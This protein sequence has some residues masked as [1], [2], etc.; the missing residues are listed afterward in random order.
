[1]N[2]QYVG[3]KTLCLP[4]IKLFD[5][6]FEYI[7]YYFQ[8]QKNDIEQL[9]NTDLLKDTVFIVENKLPLRNS[10]AF[11]ATACFSSDKHIYLNEGYLQ[12][13]WE[14][15][16]GITITWHELIHIPTIEKIIP[17][18]KYFDNKPYSGYLLYIADIH[19]KRAL[20][21]LHNGNL[22]N[23]YLSPW[24]EY[25]GISKILKDNYSSPRYATHFCEKGYVEL[26]NKVFGFALCYTLFHEVAHCKLNHLS[27]H[28]QLYQ[29]LES[30][31]ITP[32]EYGDK[33]RILE[34]E[35]DEYARSAF[36][37][38][39]DD[40]SVIQVLGSIIGSSVAIFFE[41]ST[42]RFD[43]PNSAYRLKKTI[44]KYANKNSNSELYSI[45]TIVMG[46]WDD[47]Y[48]I[49]TFDLID[50]QKTHEETFNEYLKYAGCPTE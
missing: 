14:L 41:N 5:R 32:K 48:K 45:G 40:D 8:N 39:K 9:I 13:L 21:F 50:N 36:H 7:D 37:L 17:D 12:Y 26:A 42:F 15:S 27:I 30:K 11:T 31:Q 38:D 10:N 49:K 18:K 3:K 28:K 25:L 33:N 47:N 43:H 24:R 22:T 16:Y 46:Y 35:A 23:C 29:Q 4:V 44:E 34:E 2:I 6:K 1:M 20:S 19:L